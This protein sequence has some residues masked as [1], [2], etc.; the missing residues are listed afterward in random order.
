MGAPSIADE[1]CAIDASLEL[2]KLRELRAEMRAFFA[3]QA[4]FNAEMRA[5]LVEI[6]ATQKIFNKDI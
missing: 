6:K 4:V 2:F 1:P 5:T 3:A